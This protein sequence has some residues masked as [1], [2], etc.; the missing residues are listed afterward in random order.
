MLTECLGTQWEGVS[1]PQ[2]S[3]DCHTNRMGG[4]VHQILYTLK[5]PCTV[6]KGENTVLTLEPHVFGLWTWQ[7]KSFN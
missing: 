5:M 6:D 2:T 3:F 4:K 1:S 7:K